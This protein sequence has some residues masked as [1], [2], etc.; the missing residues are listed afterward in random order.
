VLALTLRLKRQSGIA[1]PM[2]IGMILIL[3]VSVGAIA[4][5][6]Y[7]NLNATKR[8]GF[9]EQA[10]SLAE[11]GVNEALGLLAAAP[12][13]LAPGAVGAGSLA[14]DSGTAAYSSSLSGTTWTFTGTGTVPPA[15]SGAGDVVRTVSVQVNVSTAGTAWQYL[16]AG[17]SSGCVV[18]DNNA[19][20]SAALYTRGDLCIADDTHVVGSPVEVEGTVTLG[21]NAT[22]GSAVTPV[23]QANLQGGCTGGVPD[24]HTCGMADHVYASSLTQTTSGIAKPTADLASWYANAKPGPSHACTSGSVPGG[25]DDDS[26]QNASR[27]SFDLTSGPAYDCQYWEGSTM[28]GR[29]SWSPS[30]NTLTAVG[31]IFFD[32]PIRLS[33]DVRYTGR[34]TVYSSSTVTSTPSTRLCGS[35]ACDAAWNPN[36]NLLVL[37]AGDS[38]ATWGFDLA[39]GS[40]YQGGAYAVTG[41]RA[42]SAAQTWGPVIADQISVSGDVGQTTPLASVP[43]GAP[44]AASTVKTVAGTW[45]G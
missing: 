2:A 34:A 39:G 12:N 1:L 27:S 32:G 10:L 40:V 8:E 14:M 26:T 17:G 23:A 44:G 24:P 4:V 6:S 3:T 30:T 9:D 18:V 35:P 33:G 22:I 21:T 13:P 16:F 28:V 19:T 11:A 7:S 5:L 15:I 36:S 29:L 20:V 43:P 25:F 42:A 37:V 41:Y 45:R 31:T 38:S